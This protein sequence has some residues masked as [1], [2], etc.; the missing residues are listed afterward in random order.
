MIV[1]RLINKQNGKSYIGLTGDTLVNRFK[2]HVWAWKNIKSKR[3]PRLYWAFKKYG[4]DCWG[5]DVLFEG[6]LEAVKN[7]EIELIEDYGTIKNGYNMSKGGDSGLAGMKLKN[8]HKKAIGEARKKYF[9][10]E[11]GKKWKE[12]LR[13]KA[14]GN[15]YGAMRKNTKHSEETKRKIGDSN[16][17]LER[18]EKQKNERSE[19]TRQLWEKGVYDTELRRLS[20]LKNVKKAQQAK[21]GTHQTEHQ[22]QR[23]TEANSDEWEISFPDGHKEIIMN[24]RKWCLEQGLDQGNLSRTHNYNGQRK[25]KGY[26][27]KRLTNKKGD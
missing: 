21:I 5:K 18:T 7:K 6:E 14:M 11:V 2:Q 25:H 23:V 17:G 10:S 3:M 8:G 13:I 19:L 4:I 9:Q 20:S 22:K 16:R 15:K 12:Q 1:Y 26:W 27:A 24:L